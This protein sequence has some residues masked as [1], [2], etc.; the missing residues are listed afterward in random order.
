MAINFKT[1]TEE[2][3]KSPLAKYCDR[4]PVGPAPSVMEIFQKGPMDP[5]KALPFDRIN[6][7]LDPEYQE[8]ETGYCVLENGNGYVCV[9]SELP[10]VTVD[11]L[12]WWYAFYPL[13]G[14]R[15]KALCP[16]KHGSVAVSDID[17]AKILDP[18]VPI[19]EKITN[20]DHFVIEDLGGG[21]YDTIYTFY[22]PEDMGFDAEKLAASDVKAIFG[23]VSISEPRDGWGKAPAVFMHVC[24]ETGDGIE[25]RTRMYL[26]CR[27][28]A[29]AIRSVLPPGL[30]LPVEAP[31]G[32]AFHTAEENAN[33]AAIL[34]D[35]YAEFGQ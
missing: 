26:G 5:S 15:Y 7:L 4:P 25:L 23:G 11:M 33:L 20:V 12:K 32:L 29:G 35:L 21:Y 19:D 18:D 16:D 3:K 27:V 34:P 10:G 17:R 6:D 28:V 13:E 8:V 22:K 2:Q 24:R 30:I 14:I 31:M 9:K 1:L